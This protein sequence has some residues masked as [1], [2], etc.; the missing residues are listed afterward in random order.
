MKL[1]AERLKELRLDRGLSR[2]ALAEKGELHP[3]TIVLLENGTHT[4]PSDITLYKLAKAFGLEVAE[5]KT[6]ILE[7]EK[8]G[9]SAESQ[10]QASP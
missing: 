7:E 5:L 3:N 10:G 2:D 6:K 9:S 4:H 8:E 1:N